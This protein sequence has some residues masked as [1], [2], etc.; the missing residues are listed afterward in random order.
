MIME[1]I[2]ER[3]IGKKTDEM[4]IQLC[5]QGDKAALDGIM[6]KYKPLVIKRPGPCFLS[7]VKRKRFDSG[8]D[9]R[10]F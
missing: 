2:K 5:R 10:T 9:D 4:L 6:E 8:R 7:A 3:A 1:E